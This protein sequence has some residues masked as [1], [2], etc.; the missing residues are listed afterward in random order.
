MPVRSAI[1]ALCPEENRI[2]RKVEERRKVNVS[3]LAPTFV[4]LNRMGRF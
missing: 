4:A 3:S 1:G 2:L